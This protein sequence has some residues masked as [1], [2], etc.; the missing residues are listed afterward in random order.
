MFKT[1]KIIPKI[2]YEFL[3]YLVLVLFFGHF[4]VIFGYLL[5]TSR[6]TLQA[7]VRGMFSNGVLYNMGISLIAGAIYPLLSIL[8]LD[9][10]K[11]RGFRL[12]RVTLAFVILCFYTALFSVN[13]NTASVFAI[14][15]QVFCYV[16]A[17]VLTVYFFLYQFLERD[18]QNF[19]HLDD[20]KRD[21][22]SAKSSSVASDERGV[23]L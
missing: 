19:A 2:R 14:I 9:R 16:A 6:T 21:E 4:G 3:I 10:A 12:L 1:L 15:V 8:I 11:F 23:N 18:Y 17:L 5:N 7:Y 20:Q 13:L 22:L